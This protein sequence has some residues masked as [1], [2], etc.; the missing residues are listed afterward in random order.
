MLTESQM[1]LRVDVERAL[2]SLPA[3]EQTAVLLLVTMELTTR[4]AAAL[5]GLP[6]MSLH[7]RYRRAVGRL[8]HRLRAHAP[9]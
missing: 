8:R 4:E 9:A 7:D 6:T 3:D 1:C 2:H 5:L